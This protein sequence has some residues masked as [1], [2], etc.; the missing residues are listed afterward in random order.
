MFFNNLNNLATPIPSTSSN[1]NYTDYR[2]LNPLA[3]VV[4]EPWFPMT[5][6]CPCNQSLSNPSGRGYTACPFGVDY[7]SEPTAAQLQMAQQ[8]PKGPL[9]NS[10]QFN[11]SG[12][13]EA[14]PVT[15]SN[16]APADQ[17]GSLYPPTDF[18]PPQL[19]PRP[20]S[21]IGVTWRY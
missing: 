10:L 19:Q 3:N 12:K 2:C 18:V 15:I 20:F 6:V 11:N 17:P 16:S 21:R 4:G 13:W 1:P 5:D 14:V 7:Y 9:L 8:A